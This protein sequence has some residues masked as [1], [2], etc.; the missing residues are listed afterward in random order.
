MT[1]FGTGGAGGFTRTNGNLTAEN[2]GGFGRSINSTAT[3]TGKARIQATI[4]AI[5]GSGS[6]LS[7]GL[8]NASWSSWIGSDGNSIGVIPDGGAVV[9]N[10]GLVATIDVLAAGDILDICFDTTAALAW[11]R[12]IRSGAGG[13]WNGSGT[14]N[15]ATGV[16]GVAAPSG[17]LGF[18]VSSDTA[19]AK[20]TVNW[21][22]SAFTL[23]NPSGFV[24][25]DATGVTSGA[26]AASGAGASLG[27]SA[28]TKASTAAAVG[29]GLASASGRAIKPIAGSG[30]GVG[31]AIGAGAGIS[32]GGAAGL[33]AGTGLASAQGRSF[34][35]AA[36]SMAGEGSASAAAVGAGVSPAWGIGSADGQAVAVVQLLSKH[37]MLVS[38]DDPHW[39]VLEPGLEPW[40]SDAPALEA[41][42]LQ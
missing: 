36:G 38:L 37:W 6:D 1:T 16:G 41:W 5:V 33:A 31:A 22:A 28:A 9:R 3:H 12:R 21:G 10:S 39:A 32:T 35:A 14:A 25:P 17:A 19:G 18:V 13:N 26:G 4:D 23:S 7:I 30:A 29:A 2:T 27:A 20:L 24:G 8:G 15:P 34:A 11:F 40:A 42:T